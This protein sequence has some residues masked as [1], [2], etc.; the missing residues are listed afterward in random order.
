MAGKSRRYG[1]APAQIPVS[2]SQKPSTKNGILLPAILFL[3]WRPHD[4]YSLLFTIFRK[5]CIYPLYRNVT[6]LYAILMWVGN[7]IP[8]KTSTLVCCVFVYTC[9]VRLY[10]AYDLLYQIYA[11]LCILYKR[12]RTFKIGLCACARACAGWS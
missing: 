6:A 7:P 9:H 10:V 12:V 4:V 2:L 3:A 1:M 5:P 11:D 8:H